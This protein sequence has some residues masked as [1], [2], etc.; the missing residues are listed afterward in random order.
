MKKSV[1][2][3]GASG[4]VGS[5]IC[6]EIAKFE[7]LNLIKIGRL[8]DIVKLVQKA[9]LVIHSANSSK[10]Y[11]ANNNPKD[12]FVDTVEKMA[13]VYSLL[14]GKKMILI[15]TVSARVQLDTPYGRNR[16]ACE[17]MVNGAKDLIFRLGPMFG[18]ENHKGALYDIIKNKK[19]YVDEKTKY[20]YAPV[21]YNAKKI[22]ELLDE[23]G[24]IELGAKNAIEL[25]RLKKELR[26]TSAFEGPDDT[27][28]LLTQQKDAPDSF[29]VIP[30][31]KN[32]N[33]E[34]IGM[35]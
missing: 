28:I 11:H 4:F 2:V 33:S 29:D 12:D 9:D 23:I 21:E 5:A 1:A 8:D 24:I 7:N 13:K 25:G 14:D 34:N 35:L 22:V 20:A 31:A 32:I 26:S 15:S 17:L 3:L 27:Q 6:K 19:V 18:E 16:R 10:R 30:F